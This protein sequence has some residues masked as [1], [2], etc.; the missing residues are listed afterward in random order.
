M[1]PSLYIQ[2]NNYLKKKAENRKTKQ[3]RRMHDT[4]RA[5]RSDTEAER[6]TKGEEGAVFSLISV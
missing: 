1:S 5:E 6:D 2:G 4:L 3:S